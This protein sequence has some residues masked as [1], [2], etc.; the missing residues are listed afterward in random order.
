[1]LERGLYIFIHNRNEYHKHTV[2]DT[3]ERTTADKNISG[4]EGWFQSVLTNAVDS[5]SRHQHKRF[6]ARLQRSGVGHY[7]TRKSQS[8]RIE[9]R[10]KFETETQ[11]Y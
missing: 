6:H 7:V 9:P 4:L 5:S 2:C 10:V 8:N 1:M 11:P 3:A